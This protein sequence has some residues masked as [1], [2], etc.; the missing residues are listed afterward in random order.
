MTGEKTDTEARIAHLEEENAHLRQ[1]QAC[2]AALISSLQLDETLHAILDTALDVAK[3]GQGSILL[4][5]A[6]RT[7]LR[8][9][10]SIGLSP[11]TIAATR[12]RPG[13]GISGRV[14]AS[15]EPILVEDIDADDRFEEKRSHERRS[16]SF[17]SLPLPY[18]EKILGVLNLSTP[19][20]DTCF[21]PSLLPLLTTLGH[22]A[23]VA[24][25][26]AELHSTQL[27]KER[28][29]QQLEMARA[30][31]ESFVPPDFHVSGDG[32]GI[33]GRNLSASAVGGDFFG[34]LDAGGG[35]Q[36]FFLGDVSGKGIAAALYMARL[37]SDIH[38]ATRSETD[39]A[40]ILATLNGHLQKR[41]LRGMFVTM[42]IGLTMPDDGCI[43]LAS[44][45]HLP[46]LLR[47]KG[48]GVRTLAPDAG[49]PLGIA[50]AY[51]EKNFDLEM[52]KGDMLLAYTDGAWEAES[53]AGD[54]FGSAGLEECLG[55]VPGNAKGSAA[56]ILDGIFGRLESFCG[57]LALRDD[58]TLLAVERK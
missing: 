42:I 29:D 5:N 57:T 48:G 19:K 8:I 47:E 44:A 32:F 35:R 46:P 24:I 43:R 21:R 34:A 49:P 36:I 1:I 45:G 38:H 40:R 33:A 26:N 51:Q 37:I 27:E 30:I 10:E 55:N 52:K 20:E 58:V 9:A 53:P 7:F 17:A 4:Y 18:R 11:E 6:E 2:T 16:R 13:E 25:A 56:E 41:Q 28:L 50:P 15:G 39:P 12:V 22:Q 3:A 14:A 23:A 31:Q 54:P